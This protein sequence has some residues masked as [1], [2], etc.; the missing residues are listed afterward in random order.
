MTLDLTIHAAE[1]LT[2]L[3]VGIAALRKLD[4]ILSILEDYPPHRHVNGKVIYPKNYEP[5]P[6]GRLDGSTT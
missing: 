2:I 4:R 6:V 1:A 3:G 5:S